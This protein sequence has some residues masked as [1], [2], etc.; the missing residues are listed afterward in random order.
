MG[1]LG[2]EQIDTI[3]SINYSCSDERRRIGDPACVVVRAP[4][5]KV[6]FGGRKE[7][8]KYSSSNIA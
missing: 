4:T 1:A 6:I 8:N 7:A 3:P 2:G 5:N